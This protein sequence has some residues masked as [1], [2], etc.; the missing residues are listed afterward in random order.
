VADVYRPP[1]FR[2]QEK[3]LFIYTGMNN[4]FRLSHQRSSGNTLSWEIGAAVEKIVR[5]RNIQADL[6]PTVGSFYD[7]RGSLIW[8]VLINDTGDQR[9]RPNVYPKAVQW[10]KQAGFYFS[11]NDDGRAAAGFVHRLPIGLGVSGR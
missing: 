2:W 6:R 7:R 9:F 11:V 10:L 3:Q 1:R 4:L 5:Q 8:A